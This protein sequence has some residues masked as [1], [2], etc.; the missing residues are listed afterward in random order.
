MELRQIGSPS[1]MELGADGPQSRMEVRVIGALSKMELG[2][3]GALSR[4]SSEQMVLRARW[5]S[6]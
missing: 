3:N 6:K 1:K 4:Q 2:A 5:S